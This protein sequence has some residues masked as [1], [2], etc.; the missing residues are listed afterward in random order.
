MGGLEC[1]IPGECDW[2]ALEDR[3]EDEGGTTKC[4]KDDPRVASQ[5]E[6]LVQEEAEVKA[7]E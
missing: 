5:A 4:G 1:P 7:Q 3:C 6:S 2:G